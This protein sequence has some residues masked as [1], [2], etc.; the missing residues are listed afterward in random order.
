MKNRNKQG[1]DSHDKRMWVNVREREKNK[2][3]HVNGAMFLT[4]SNKGQTWK[5]TKAMI[6]WE[7]SRS[8][9]MKSCGW[10]MVVR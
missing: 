10:H 7:Q 3:K 6:G 4:V 9:T 2:E 1:R 8:V 5:P